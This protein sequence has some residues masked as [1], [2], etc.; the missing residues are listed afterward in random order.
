MGIT[1]ITFKIMPTSPQADLAKL[2]SAVEKKTAELG[3]KF[4]SSTEEPIAFGIKALMCV[5]EWPEEKDPDVIE[6]ALGKLKDVN[7][8]QMTDVRRLIF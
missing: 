2:K 7:S 6:G 4:K 8:V 1:S 5:V 3:G